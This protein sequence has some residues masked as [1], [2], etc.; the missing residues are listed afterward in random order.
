MKSVTDDVVAFILSH[1][2]ANNCVTWKTLKKIGFTGRVKI[3]ID[4]EDG[5]GDLYRKNFGEENVITFCKAE[6]MKRPC[7][8]DNFMTRAT[9][10]YARNA[11]FRIA[12]EVGCKYFIMLD[13]DYSY[14]TFRREIGGKFTS[15]IVYHDFDRIV[16]AYIDFLED[17]KA[18]VL[19]CAQNGDYVGGPGSMA[20][21]NPI[22]RKAMNVYFFKTDAEP[23]YFTGAQND[24]VN[25]YVLAN[26]RGRLVL[27][28]TSLSM[29][30]ACTQTAEGGLTEMY[31]QFGTYTKS[32][33]TVVVAPSCC[34]V[35]VLGSPGKNRTGHYRA[36]HRISWVHTAPMILSEKWKKRKADAP[37]A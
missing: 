26:M 21:K 35:H 34:Q 24:D 33:S 31:R 22:L 36:H 29:N 28:S 20:Y 3:I 17:S 27:T 2:R 5:Q 14:F 1:G 32:F 12:K 23:Y 11:T 6:E 9:V 30:Q 13:D 37:A 15:L 16:E 8:A 10:L 19:C 4:D 18:A 7:H 25:T